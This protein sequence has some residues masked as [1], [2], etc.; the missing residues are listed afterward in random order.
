MSVASRCPS[1]SAAVRPLAV[2]IT[3]IAVTWSAI[4]AA[5][6][7]PGGRSGAHGDKDTKPVVQGAPS[8]R[9]A[10]SADGGSSSDGDVTPDARNALG[11]GAA[12]PVEQGVLVGRV[13]MTDGQAVVSA[14]VSVVSSGGRVGNTQSA[15]TEVARVE[16]DDA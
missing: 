4:D 16:P 14:T 5:Q 12:K 1:E 15:T 9:D 2:A 3:V 8:D 11:D 13:V 10:K 7:E 6:A